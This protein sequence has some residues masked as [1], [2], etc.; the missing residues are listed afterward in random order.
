MRKL[1]CC[2][3]FLIPLLVFSQFND[4]TIGLLRKL[5]SIRNSATVSRHFAG[6]YFNVTTGAMDYFSKED[7]TVQHFMQRLENRFADYFFNAAAAY[8]SGAGMPVAWKNYYTDTSLTQVQY[9]LLGANAHINGDIW[10]ALTSEFSLQELNQYKRFYYR[11]NKK[12]KEEILSIYDEAFNTVPKVRLLHAVSAGLDKQYGKLMLV[13]WRKRQMKI[14][15]LWFTDRD[16]FQIKLTSIRKK[17]AKLD[18]LVLQN[19]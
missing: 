17:M 3:F 4:T 8:N 1:F 13:R 14:S 6:L 19:L 18:K 16:R 12:L 11:Y 7:K 2:L 10:Q 9:F 5:D 15:M